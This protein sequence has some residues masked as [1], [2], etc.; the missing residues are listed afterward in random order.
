MHLGI[1]Q[2]GRQAVCADEM[3]FRNKKPRARAGF[4]LCRLLELLRCAIE[5]HRDGGLRGSFCGEAAAQ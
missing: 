5:F 3:S 4:P 1:L 2:R